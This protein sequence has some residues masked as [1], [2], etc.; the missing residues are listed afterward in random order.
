MKAKLCEDC[1]RLMAR[2]PDKIDKETSRWVCE[3][4]NS[5]KFDEE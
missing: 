2:I 4:C 1:H 5:V 3:S